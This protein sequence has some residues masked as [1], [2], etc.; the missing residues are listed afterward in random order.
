MASKRSS[1]PTRQHLQGEDQQGQAA[2]PA[3]RSRKTHHTAGATKS[4]QS[5]AALAKEELKLHKAIEKAIQKATKAASVQDSAHPSPSSTALHSAAPLPRETSPLPLVSGPALSPDG[6]TPPTEAQA[7]V[8]VTLFG[9]QSEPS[10]NPAPSSIRP[11]A[12]QP[13]APSDPA[14]GAP[15]TLITPILASYIKEAIREG[16]RQELHQR[17]SSWVSDQEGSQ[18]D[19]EGSIISS[20][21]GAT[22]CGEPRNSVQIGAPSS[23]HSEQGSLTGA[24]LL[25]QEMSEDEDLAPDQPAFVGLFKPQLF[26]SLLHKAKLTTGLGVSRPSEISPKEGP[27]TSVPLFEE[28]IIESEEI[29]GPKIFRDVLQRQWSSPA[30]G[31]SPNSLDKRIYNLAPEL[32]SLLQAPSVDQPV[33][34]LSASSN[35]AGPP[36]DNLR[37]EDRRLE[38]SLVRSHQ[39]TAWSIRS[40]MAASFFNRASILWLK[41]LQARLP[42]SD[43][44]AQQD[45]SK[46]IVAL[47]YS[48]DATLNSSRFAA[49]AIGSTVTS[50]RLLWLRQ[51]QADSKSKWRLAS[52]A[53]EGPKL[54]GA[55]LDPLLVESKDKRR[56]L[57]SMSRRS[58]IRS[59]SSFRPFRN[60]EGGFTG[61]R[62][63]RFFPPRQ[64]RFQD[65]QFPSSSRG[66]AR[67][68]FRGG[69]GRGFRRS[70]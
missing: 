18:L 65:R 53:F 30:S 22:H 67:R 10:P 5:A 23:G 66:Q 27:S 55:A 42:I 59:Q 19:V 56:V 52:S 16:V 7:G 12:D 45:I 49:K 31:P 61:A 40:T 8:N 35:L 48:A 13:G 54:F 9:E 21:R 47:E 43:V 36:E 34:E 32:S 44:R 28:P 38:H 2:I 15:G 70:R 68:P 14:P 63:Q 29:P 11:P 46:V 17:T 24:D 4:A 1:R 33:A 39:A 50:R 41:Q 62:R 26:R 64:S 20:G 25:D 57:P 69:R 51:W 60:Q 58:E 6:P 3:K 37:P